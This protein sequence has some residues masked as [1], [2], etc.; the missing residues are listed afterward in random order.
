MVELNHLRHFYEVARAGSFTA[1]SRSL[2]VSQSALSKTVALLEAREGVQLL[3]RSKSG[4][5]LTPLGAKV[6]AEAERIFSAVAGIQTTFRN[7][8]EECEGV[9]RL[10]ASDHIANYLLAPRVATLRER[11]PK[12]VPSIFSAT[13]ME[14]AELILKDELEFG[15]SF[16]RMNIPGLIYEPWQEAEMAVVY[17]AD[18]FPN[19]K[20]KTQ[21]ALLKTIGYISN[22]R[23]NPK[24]RVS[25]EFVKLFGR[26]PEHIVVESNSQETQKR[27]CLAG[28][29]FAYLARFM[30]AEEI[31]KKIL[32]EFELREPPMLTI[33]VS[34]KKS[35]PLSYSARI[36]LGLN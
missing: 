25:P 30:V 6:F 9:L 14:T 26:E 1:A 2:N 8:K 12:L 3:L 7:F 32:T 15:L 29:G 34:R 11:Y 20:I 22:K 18:A 27:L 24:E 36:F 35:V 10:G 31:Q 33:Y 21:A 17:R 5:T 23:K 28:V 19:A 4:V 13:P 16:L